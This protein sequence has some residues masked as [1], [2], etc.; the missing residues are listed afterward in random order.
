MIG[1][2]RGF[3]KGSWYVR[4]LLLYWLWVRLVV[5]LSPFEGH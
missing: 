4:R 5:W 2:V 3:L 1:F